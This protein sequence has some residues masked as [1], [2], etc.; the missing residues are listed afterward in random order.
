MSNI[1]Q[2]TQDFYKYIQ[3]KYNASPIRFTLKDNQ[4]WVEM[5]NEYKTAK[6][7]YDKALFRLNAVR[8]N[9]IRCSDNDNAYGN[10]VRVEKI[11]SKGRISYSKIPQLKEMDL[12]QY[13]GDSIESYRV[14][15]DTEEEIDWKI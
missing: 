9:L 6:Q 12:E 5:T 3:N 2:N 7:E 14:I 13:R 11:V 15:E 4:E 10:G 1:E 8:G